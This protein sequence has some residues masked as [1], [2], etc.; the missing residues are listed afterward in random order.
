MISRDQEVARTIISAI[1]I[2]LANVSRYESGKGPLGMLRYALA[3]TAIVTLWILPGCSRRVENET[4][5]PDSGATAT[6][7]TPDARAADRIILSRV[8]SVSYRAASLDDVLDDLLAK[9]GLRSAYLKSAGW[10]VSFTYEKDGATVEEVLSELCSSCG[11]GRS[12]SGSVVLLWKDADLRAVHRLEKRTV[13][14]YYE[15][16]SLRRSLALVSL[17][18]NTPVTIGPLRGTAVRRSAV[19][20]RN[21]TPH[22]KQTVELDGCPFEVRRAG[23]DG[24]EDVASPFYFNSSDDSA[25]EAF[26]SIARLCGI[27]S[28]ATGRG[29][30]IAARTRLDEFAQSG[31]AVPPLPEP[32]PAT[33]RDLALFAR[34]TAAAGT[35]LDEALTRSQPDHRGERDPVFAHLALTVRLRV[36]RILR[37]RERL[38]GEKL[39]A[40]LDDIAR[41]SRAMAIGVWPFLSGPGIDDL[42]RHACLSDSAP[43]WGRDIEAVVEGM[44][45]SLR[46]EFAYHAAASEHGEMRASG[47]RLL[48]TIATPDGRELIL[49]ALSDP[50][51]DVRHAA[52]ETLVKADGPGAIS[53]LARA[54]SNQD[55]DDIVEVA[56]AALRHIGSDEAEQALVRMRRMSRVSEDYWHSAM[57]ALALARIGSQNSMTIVKEMLNEHDGEVASSFIEQISAPVRHAGALRVVLDVACMNEL[58]ARVAR[59]RDEVRSRLDRRGSWHFNETLFNKAVREIERRAGIECVASQIGAWVNYEAQDATAFEALDE[60]CKQ[61]GACFK[62]GFDHRKPGGIVISIASADDVLNPWRHRLDYYHHARRSAIE[63][64]LELRGNY[65]RDRLL[66]QAGNEPSDTMRKVIVDGLK[67][68]W[69]HDSRVLTALEALETPDVEAERRRQ[70]RL[71]GKASNQMLGG[72]PAIAAEYSEKEFDPLHGPVPELKVGPKRPDLNRGPNE[73]RELF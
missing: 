58:D 63:L 5:E 22:V 64:L 54:L 71:R 68:H 17:L 23:R 40:A 50:E 32:R 2:C 69:A 36:T 62:V 47:I 46:S 21:G 37:S 43:P 59:E 16:L 44:P 34:A 19:F 56:T 13:R 30:L 57:V 10:N 20:K 73:G 18:T 26:G 3:T 25:R 6:H 41:T 14:I 8:V 61:A 1:P 72:T 51:L 39:A 55:D 4:G 70:Q 29:M 49:K 27:E 42:A 24:Q 31:P 48:G 15:A 67:R 12:R 66:E 65:I 11:L 9:A 28:T 7:N 35:N 38:G 60:I 53:H 52:I 45:T 33:D